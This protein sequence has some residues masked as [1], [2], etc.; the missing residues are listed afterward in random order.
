MKFLTAFFISALLL[1]A[2]PFDSS[3]VPQGKN[4]QKQPVTGLNLGNRAPEISMKN[5]EGKVMKLS[6]LKGK[7]VLIDF[8]ASWCGPCRYEN[9]TVV[10]AYNAYKD[11]KFAG[12]KGFTIFSVSLDANMEAW[13]KAILQDN[14]A[15]EHHVSD[16]QGWNSAAA[17][18]YAVS[19]IPYNVL[20]ND[21]GIIINKNLR[22]EQLLSALEKLV[23]K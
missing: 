14:L 21:K 3:S 15:W 5:P 12:G 13:K 18:Q 22:G 4:S 11:K 6:A 7:L 20:I 1:G 19:G 17:A 23:I 16:L 10:R 8:W 9:P 2:S